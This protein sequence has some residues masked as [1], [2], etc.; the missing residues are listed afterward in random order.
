VASRSECCRRTPDVRQHAYG[1]LGRRDG[2]PDP[3]HAEP[4]AADLE[5]ASALRGLVRGG[6]LPA[7]EAQRALGL[8]ASM[9]IRRFDHVALLPRV[10]ELRHSMGPY[11]AAYVALAEALDVDLVTVDR[12]MAGVP[13]MR[14]TVRVPRGD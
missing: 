5:C 12:K 3:A 4:H 14:C 9:S 7:D 13:N 11:D 6:K 8:L 10:W 1:R 2:R